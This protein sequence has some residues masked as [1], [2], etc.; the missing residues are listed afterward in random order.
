MRV[1]KSM[2]DQTG[3]KVE[4]F[5][6]RSKS[7]FRKV[8]VN[9]SS[10]KERK[11]ESCKEFEEKHCQNKKNLS[12]ATAL[13]NQQATEKNQSFKKRNPRLPI[14]KKRMIRRTFCRLQLGRTW[15]P[16]NKKRGNNTTKK[17]HSTLTTTVSDLQ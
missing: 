5:F 3:G 2:R 4:S 13:I 14:A 8:L 17:Q 6:N 16:R 11:Q 15:P 7:I 12:N 9:C 1:F 10:Q